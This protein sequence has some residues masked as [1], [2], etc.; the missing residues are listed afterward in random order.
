VNITNLLHWTLAFLAAALLFALLGFT[1]IAGAAAGF[2]KTLFWIAIIL[3][4]VSFM[5]HTVRGA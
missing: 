1:G 3:A 4:I 2:A 5:V